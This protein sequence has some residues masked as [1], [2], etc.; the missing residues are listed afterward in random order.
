MTK[1][2]H[3]KPILS[4]RSTFP[5]NIRY[6]HLCSSD[7]HANRTFQT[8][9]YAEEQRKF[10]K[11]RNMINEFI[12]IMCWYKL[13]LFVRLAEPRASG[14]FIGRK[15]TAIICLKLYSVIANT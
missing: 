6:R 10:M 9:L 15:L 11:Q 4:I 8:K 12:T 5:Y 2:E 3:D 1:A 7:N 14:H 13:T